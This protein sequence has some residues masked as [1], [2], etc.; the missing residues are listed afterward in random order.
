MPDARRVISVS[1]KQAARHRGGYARMQRRD[2]SMQPPVLVLRGES[3]K[4]G[5]PSHLSLVAT[6]GREP[7]SVLSKSPASAPSI[8]P[9]CIPRCSV[10]SVVVAFHEP[11]RGRLSRLSHSGHCH[12]GSQSPPPL[13]WHGESG[14]DRRAPVRKPALHRARFTVPRRDSRAVESLQ[15]Q[16][17]HA[18]GTSASKI[19]TR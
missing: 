16:R 11:A 12:G 15:Q 2:L 6:I 3:A 14:Q 5:C 13:R 4:E 10:S 18:A 9:V 8:E 7:Q 1:Q 19:P 17:K